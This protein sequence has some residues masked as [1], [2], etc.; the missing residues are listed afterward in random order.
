M[1]DWQQ[2]LVTVVAA[3]ALVVVMRPLLRKR[4]GDVPACPSCASGNACATTPPATDATPTPQVI[5]L[6]G[7]KASRSTGIDRHAG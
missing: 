6:A 5:P 4:S 1:F 7:L 3:A 2:L